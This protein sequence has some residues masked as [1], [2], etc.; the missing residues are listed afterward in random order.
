MR[1]A[2]TKTLT[3]CFVLVL[4]VQLCFLGAL[5]EENTEILV[6]KTPTCGC[7][8]KWV[9]HLESHGFEVV[10]ENMD[11]LSAIKRAHAVPPRLQ[12]CHTAIVDGYVV[13]GHVPGDLVQRLLREKPKIAGLAVPE[14]PVGSPGM[15]MGDH[16][17]PYKVL[18]FDEAGEV[19]LYAER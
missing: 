13:E 10:T 17:Q 16:R 12:S 14:M 11:D 18:A 9:H 3:K 19:S 4:L 8:D 6:Y 2:V 7:C 5:A 1:S 15:E